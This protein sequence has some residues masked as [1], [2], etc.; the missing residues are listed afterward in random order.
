MHWAPEVRQ[1]RRYNF[2]LQASLGFQEN[3]EAEEQTLT[4][5]NAEYSHSLRLDALDRLNLHHRLGV[6]GTYGEVPIYRAAT[7]GGNS[8]LRGYRMDR[9]AG[10]TSFYQNLELRWRTFA[11]QN[12]LLTGQSGIYGFT[13]L[14]RVFYEEENSEK[15]HSS[16]G[17]GLWF[18]LFNSITFSGSAAYS[19][20]G[21]YYR[22]N[23]GFF[24]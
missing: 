16:L 12:Y 20:E 18:R 7:L 22:F 6:Q 8:N 10:N 17:G 23:S 11:F 13:D 2:Q 3:L 5:G 14:G 9:F 19:S 1:E 21:V 24:F 4:Y 15:W